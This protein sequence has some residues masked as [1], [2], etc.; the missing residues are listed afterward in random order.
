MKMSAAVFRLRKKR[1]KLTQQAFATKLGISTSSI[2][3]WES[4][5]QQPDAMGLMKLMAEASLSGNRELALFFGNGL[6]KGHGAPNGRVYIPPVMTDPFE[7]L[8]ADTVLRAFF[9]P[10]N[11]TH[12]IVDVIGAAIED[13][14]RATWFREEAVRRDLIPRE[15]GSSKK[16]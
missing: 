13:P 11:H 4:G 7:Q 15:E 1:L 9:V 12:A 6:L 3:N 8:A 2:Q 14:E 5:R 16:K 10:T